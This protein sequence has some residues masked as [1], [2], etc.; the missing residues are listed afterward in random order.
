MRTRTGRVLVAA[1]GVV[2]VG[3]AVAA[4]TGFGFSLRSGGTGDPTGELP[5]ATAKITRQT[6]V[7]S[8]SE[9]G[10]LGYGDDTAIA[11]RIAGTI[12]GLPAVGSTVKR[13]QAIY[14]VDN[15]PVVLLYG[16]LPA[17]RAL[18]SGTEGS[19]VKQFERN[20]WELGYRG[21]TVDTTYTSA[22]ADAV[23]EWQEDLGL[24]E[25]GVVEL[26]R[27]VYAAGAVRVDSHKAA[28]GDAAGPGAPV[29]AYTGT[30]RVITVVLDADQQSLAK[31]GTSVTVS[32][33]DGR[34][35]P[36]TIA[37]T[38]TVVETEDNGPSGSREVTR[39]KVT[40]AV[41]DQKAF[42]GLDQAALDVGFAARKRENVLTVP[43]AALLALAEGGY[44]VEVVTGSTSRIVAVT[45]G[46]FAHG[47]VE[48][49]GDGL[50]EGM[51]VGIPK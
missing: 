19:D 31:K 51:T 6:L 35:L 2:A 16:S 18:S 49:A 4:A 38:A 12:T 34:A 10:E 42:A 13:G 26:G 39:I 36:A 9:T 43:V 11:G 15:T 45:T 5:P 47:R 3:A 29:L 1:A 41:A 27:V 46:L 50:T 40:V 32:L 20:L 48:V 21:F 33:P 28:V 8:V 30:A 7:D 24:P 17:Y 22:T 14:R 37:R 44:G 25:T 23:E